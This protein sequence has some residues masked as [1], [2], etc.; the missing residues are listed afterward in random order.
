[1]EHPWD[2][3]KSIHIISLEQHA[4][5]REKVAEILDRFEGC[6]YS[7]FDAVDGKRNPFLRKSFLERHII[8]EDAKLSDG[9]LGCLASHRAIWE[10][11]LLSIKSPEPFWILIMEDDVAFHPDFNNTLLKEY[12]ENIPKDAVYL[13]FGYLAHDYYSK[14]HSVSNKY[15]M[16]FNGQVSFS[17]VCYAVQSN[18]LHE[19]IKN[20]FRVPVDCISIGNSYG[21]MNLEIVLEKEEDK[22]FRKYV[23]PIY[24]CVEYFYGIAAVHEGES[25]TAPIKE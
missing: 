6:K 5:K 2:F 24:K 11:E 19:L 20:T 15:W 8:S 14:R 22:E 13:K 25:D 10:K 23:N 21:A 9:Q 1:M 18:L 16:D 3:F 4:K 7:F 17:T 12:L